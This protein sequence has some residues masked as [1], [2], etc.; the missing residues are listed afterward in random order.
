MSKNP[1]FFPTRS[2]SGQIGI[3]CQGEYT[4]A[5]SVSL[6]ES[7]IYFRSLQSQFQAGQSVV[8]TF[9]IP[10]FSNVQQEFFIQKGEV[11][12]MDAVKALPSQFHRVAV[13]KS[14]GAQLPLILFSEISSD[15]KKKIRNYHISKDE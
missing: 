1:F 15:L 3:L 12:Y 4:L 6:G 8:V 9:R 5:E 7:G 13:V 10:H 14:A 2:L 11:A